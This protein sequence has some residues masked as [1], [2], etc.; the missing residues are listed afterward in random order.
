MNFNQRR[1]N[2]IQFRPWRSR[3]SALLGFLAA[4]WRCTLNDLR[5]ILPPVC[6]DYLRYRALGFPR[7]SAWFNAKNRLGTG[8]R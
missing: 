4:D 5:A 7:R 2:V 1:S 3:W 8:R 6:R